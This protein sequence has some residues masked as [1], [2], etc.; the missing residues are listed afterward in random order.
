MGVV[1]KLKPEIVNFV[2]D[3]K[4]KNPSLSCR[5]LVDIVNATLNTNLS[6]SSVNNILKHADL[7]SSVGRRSGSGQYIRQESSKKFKLSEAKRKSIFADSSAQP[8]L[9]D[10]KWPTLA[11]DLMDGMGNVFLKAAEWDSSS[12]PIL[13]ALLKESCPNIDHDRIKAVASIVGFLKAFQIESF[14]GLAHYEGQGL[15][16]LNQIEKAITEED[17]LDVVENLK[18]PQEFFLKFSLKAPQVFSR[19]A[20]FRYVLKDGSNFF[21]DGQMASVWKKVQTQ[22]SVSLS[23]ATENLAKML[24]NVQSEVFC[25]ISPKESGKIQQTRQFFELVQAFENVQSKR[26]QHIE[27]LG[28]NGQI[29]GDFDEVPQIQR[30]F[31]AGVWPWEKIFHQFLDVKKIQQEGKIELDFLEREMTFKEV[32]FNWNEGRTVPVRGI[33]LYE[34]F[35]RLP[36][37]ILITNTDGKTV[38]AQDVVLQYCQRWPNIEKGSSFSVFSDPARWNMDFSD[39][40]KPVWDILLGEQSLSRD[41]VWMAADLLVSLLDRF[42]KKQ[43]FPEG[44]ASADFY[45]MRNRFYSLPGKIQVTNRGYLAEIVVPQGSPYVKDALFAAQ[46]VNES[47]ITAFDGRQLFIKLIY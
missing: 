5:G 35:M 3:Q 23:K 29:L 25:S 14:E 11:E 30:F 4:K 13:E 2:I 45:T 18:N 39:G 1:H 36:F 24:N 16:A 38:P 47:G 12:Q 9:A 43:F 26:I 27:L 33:L 32:F 40:E 46:R 10:L 28:E 31:I 20:G 15:W 7:S 8:I 22:F 34:A 41:P 44:Y 17:V 6:K 19:A 21:L 42:A 37:L